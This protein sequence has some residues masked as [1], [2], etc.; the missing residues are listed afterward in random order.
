[1]RKLYDEYFEC[2]NLFQHYA[3]RHFYDYGVGFR[4]I[5]TPE[6]HKYCGEMTGRYYKLMMKKRLEIIEKYKI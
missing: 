2:R 5:V 3:I 6:E 1:M 4:T